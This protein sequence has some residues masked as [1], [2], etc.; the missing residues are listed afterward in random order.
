MDPRFTILL[1]VIRPPA[2][3]PFVID[4]VLAQ[5]VTDFELFVV[6]DGAPEA[7]I[8]CARSYAA[9]DPRV[10]VFP[11]PKGAGCGEAHRHTALAQARGRFVAHIGDDDLWFPNHLE[12]LEKL[13]TEA[14]F[15]HLIHVEVRPDGSYEV[16]P[17]NLAS[18]K[19]RQRILDE[20]FNTLG[21]TVTGYRLDAYRSL[22]EGW[23]PPPEMA[24]PDLK[25]WRKFLCRDN[26]SFGTRA[27]VTALIFADQKRLGMSLG[28][29]HDPLERA[30]IVQG[31]WRSVVEDLVHAED[32]RRARLG[33]IHALQA[34]VKR[35][36]NLSDC[37]LA[38]DGAI[39]FTES[40]NSPLYTVSGWS[41]QEIDRRW[42]DG[43]EAVIRVRPERPQG[44]PDPRFIRL[45]AVAFGKPQRVTVLVNGNGSV[46]L[47]V[48]S[49]WRDYEV[50]I[51][52]VNNQADNELKFLLP[53][54]HS[55]KSVG[56]SEDTRE[57]GIA[58][59]S[60]RFLHSL[61]SADG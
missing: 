51:N 48:D 23:A 22:P 39:D 43:K 45:R 53:D 41:D 25:M 61:R 11:F 44:A 16:L 58:L 27:V 34:Q 12:E 3:L 8:A 7:T 32:D 2:M 37:R 38:A 15:G 59:S 50:A 47:T 46:E 33:V 28:R 14:D 40:G 19:F 5:S 57:L 9:R 52:S 54:A 30:E 20:V 24:F 17:S 1:P 56:Q 10:K 26:L 49:T 4:T 29:L 13:L 35:L 42:T 18:A 31:A 60:L 6:G 21:D 55:P 36:Q